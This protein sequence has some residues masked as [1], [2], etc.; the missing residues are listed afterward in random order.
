MSNEVI[1]YPL[2][3]KHLEPGTTLEAGSVEGYPSLLHTS[4]RAL[5]EHLSF[6]AESFHFYTTIPVSE[7]PSLDWSLG[8][9]GEVVVRDQCSIELDAYTDSIYPL[10]ESE[11]SE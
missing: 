1:Y 5:R 8:R 3:N 6:H 4:L 2:R 7:I 11:E 9:E 10:W